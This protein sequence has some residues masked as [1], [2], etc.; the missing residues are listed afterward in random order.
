MLRALA[1]IVLPW[2]AVHLFQV[3]E[4][5]AK[6]GEP[7]RNL[8]QLEN[9]LLSQVP[10]AL[11]RVHGMPV[12]DPDLNR[13]LADYASALESAAGRPP[14]LDIVH[15]GLGVDG[16]TASLVS[17][18][19]ALNE[20]QSDVALTQ[21]Y[22][23]YRRMTLTVPCLARARC[24]VWLVTGPDKA[25]AFA[26]LLQRDPGLPGS[27]LAAVPNTYF[28]DRAAASELSNPHT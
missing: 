5:L 2:H 12:E 7:A 18:D 8:T 1:T 15:L 14:V 28:V 3:D 4:R 10:I 21:R 19:P 9:E 11:D 17:G 25:K 16:H 26:Q 24:R 27:Q 20:T 22:N 13:A 6:R 23:G